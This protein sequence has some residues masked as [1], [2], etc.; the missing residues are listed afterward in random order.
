MKVS[1]FVFIQNYF[2]YFITLAPLSFPIYILES[3]FIYWQRNLVEILIE[4]ALNL[5]IIL[6]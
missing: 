3:S 2:G 1:H 5:Q 4:F 6:G